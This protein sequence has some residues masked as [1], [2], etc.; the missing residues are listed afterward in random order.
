MDAKAT[1]LW[2]RLP[3]PLTSR[4]VKV[5]LVIERFGSGGGGVEKVGWH[6]AR[7]L[8]KREVEVSIVCRRC[9]EAPPPRVELRLVRTPSFWQPLRVLVFSR[10][11]AA[12][13]RAGYDIV[14]SLARIRYSDIF[15]TGGGS[16]AAY[17]ENVYRAPRARALLSPRHQV[18]LRIEEAV[19]R[20]PH[21]IIQCNARASATEISR[22]YSV[23]ESRLVTIYNGVDTEQFHPDRRREA[24]DTTRSGLGLEGPVALFVGTGFHRKGLDR[25]LAGFARGAPPDATLLVA[26]GDDPAPYRRLAQQLGLEN[27]VRFLGRR[28]DVD[29]LHA[30]SDLLVLPTRYDPFANSCLEAMASGLPVATTPTNGAAELIET[31]RNGLVV[32]GEFEGAFALLGAPAQLHAMGTAAR[33]TAERYTWE[34]HTDRVLDLYGRVRE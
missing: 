8:A 9:E 33:A 26:G 23:P 20:D 21:P 16:H 30:A 7:E 28:S 5:A 34:A 24:R 11:A 3:A 12:E 1:A 22:R 25:A 27:R 31:G 2:Q 6:L 15:R 14:H 18:L 4:S 13:V 10:R 17:M 29:R 32:D 19:F